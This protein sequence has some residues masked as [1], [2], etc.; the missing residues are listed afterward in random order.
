ML[1]RR[2]WIKWPNA[3]AR[4][5]QI[6]EDDLVNDVREMIL[7]KHANSL[8]RSFDSPNATLRIVPRDA[9]RGQDRILGPEEKMCR[10]LDAYFPGGQNVTEALIIDV[11]Q[12]RTPKPSPRVPIYYDHDHQDDHRNHQTEYFPLVPIIAPSPTA[13]SSQHDA[14]IPLPHAPHSIAVLNTGQLPP[15]PS[16]SCTRKGPLHT[17]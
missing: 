7:N 1:H 9:Q 15:L 11:P 17:H 6:C 3:S 8:G 5:V 2:I 16:P 10:T 4:L 12:R 14:R 13:T